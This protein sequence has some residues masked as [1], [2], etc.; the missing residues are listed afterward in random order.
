MKYL[1][2][3]LLLFAP[4]CSAADN[5]TKLKIYTVEQYRQA[6][7]KE[8]KKYVDKDRDLYWGVTKRDLALLA[9]KTL[10]L[11]LSIDYYMKCT[12]AIDDYESNDSLRSLLED[13]YFFNRKGIR[14][15]HSSPSEAVLYKNR[16]LITYY[17]TDGGGIWST[18][19]LIVK[20]KKQFDIYT[21]DE[22][23]GDVAP[24]EPVAM[25]ETRKEVDMEHVKVKDIKLQKT[26][27]D[28]IFSMNICNKHS[29]DIYFYKTFIPT[30]SRN[31]IW[32]F[33]VFQDGKEIQYKGIRAKIKMSKFPEG[34]VAI[35]PNKCLPISVK[36]NKYFDFDQNKEIQLKYFRSLRCPSCSRKNIDIDFT[37]NLLPE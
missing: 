37:I 33:E 14:E 11:K 34:Y 9:P 7:S 20:T 8:L 6:H 16:A 17:G 36:L 19:K 22:W 27:K 18:I 24:V 1:I 25:L 31:A 3:F 15:Y 21:I 10:N 12:I 28:S 30:P 32:T 35:K 23:A 29:E 5:K 4:I 2:L 13:E 26:G